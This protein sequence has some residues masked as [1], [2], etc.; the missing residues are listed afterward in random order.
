MII[1]DNYRNSLQTEMRPDTI[2]PEAWDAVWSNFVAE[3]PICGQKASHSVP[4]G[5]IQQKQKKWH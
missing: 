5:H 1:Q 4:I 3:V 2:T